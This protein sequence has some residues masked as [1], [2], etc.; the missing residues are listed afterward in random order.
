MLPD[1]LLDQQFQSAFLPPHEAFSLHP[2]YTNTW[3]YL[4][5]YRCLPVFLRL[6]FMGIRQCCAFT[7]LQV[8][9]GYAIC[10]EQWNIQ[11]S[12][13]R[14][15]PSLPC[16]AYFRVSVLHGYIFLC[17]G[18][19]FKRSLFSVQHCAIPLAFLRR[20]QISLNLYLKLRPGSGRE[21]YQRCLPQ[22][23]FFCLFRGQNLLSVFL[24]A[25]S[26]IYNVKYYK[27]LFWKMFLG[28]PDTYRAML[29]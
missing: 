13:L 21:P 7:P 24:I 9:C 20:N 29:H 27:I 3:N 2:H 16:E 8:R 14:V 4:T 18:L 10:S 1:C 6:L 15:V 11:R 19:H 22:P 5:K 25:Q 26:I 23:T 17:L 28:T 12:D